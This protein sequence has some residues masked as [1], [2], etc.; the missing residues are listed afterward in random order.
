MSRLFF[1][2]LSVSVATLAGIG[3]IIAL[4]MGHYTSNAVL[5]AALVG[6]VAAFPI[7]WAVARR[8]EDSDPLR[9]ET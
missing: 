2:L 8:I 9:D 3:V 4:V 5:I 6:A 7:S 1:L